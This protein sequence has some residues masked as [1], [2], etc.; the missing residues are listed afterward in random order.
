MFSLPALPSLI[1]SESVR[2]DIYVRDGENE[3]ERDSICLFMYRSLYTLASSPSDVSALKKKKRSAVFPCAAATSSAEDISAVL[4]LSSARSLR[5]YNFLLSFFRFVQV[6]APIRETGA[7][8][9][10]IICNRLYG[11][12]QCSMLLSVL[13]RLLQYDGTWEVRH[14]ALVTLK[15]TFNILKVK[16]ARAHLRLRV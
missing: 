14:G 10:A 2:E 13:L 8:A 1:H 6:V 11:R 4:Y 12:P 16:R 7:Q 5:R 15:Y 9:L 3:R